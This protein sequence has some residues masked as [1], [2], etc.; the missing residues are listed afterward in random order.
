MPQVELIDQ[1][2][3]KPAQGL[4]E[5]SLKVE[6]FVVQESESVP[7][8]DWIEDSYFLGTVAKDL[9]PY[10]R[11]VIIEFEEVILKARGGH[12]TDKSGD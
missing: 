5:S 8:R 11:E 2:E 7:V 10:W 1:S 3:S 12:V 4:V 6:K 9:Y